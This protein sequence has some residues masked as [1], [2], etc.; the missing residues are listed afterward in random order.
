VLVLGA[1]GAVGGVL[2]DLLA[3]EPAE[4]V[5]ANRTVERAV[6]LLARFG[7]APQAVACGF[8][9]L[10]GRRFDIIVN[11]TSL[12][13]TGR[14]PPLPDGV[15]APAGDCYDML[16]GAAARPFCDWAR[17]AGAARVSDGLGMLVEQ[18]AESFL[19]WR[20]VRPDT[21]PVLAALRSAGT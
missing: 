8:A 5:I 9:A 7:G 3:L 18:A 21:G 6:A 2:P 12:G 15:L 13:L 19:V 14:L 17:A 16:Y 10:A 20:G 1:G 11:G 4:V